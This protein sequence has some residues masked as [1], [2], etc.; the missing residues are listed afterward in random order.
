MERLFPVEG[1]GK[2]RSFGDA[3]ID[4][5]RVNVRAWDSTHATESAAREVA[6]CLGEICL[7]D[8][9]DDQVCAMVQLTF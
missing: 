9:P 2:V 4:T 3:Y 1:G 6:R 8:K 7:A 5:H